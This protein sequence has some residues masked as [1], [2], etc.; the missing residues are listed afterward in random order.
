[1]VEVLPVFSI[2]TLGSSDV[3]YKTAD[4]ITVPAARVGSEATHASGYKIMVIYNRKRYNQ[5]RTTL[6]DAI[7]ISWGINGAIIYNI[8]Q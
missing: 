7:R 3:K 4:T 2:I 1:M 8:L 6:F 5:N